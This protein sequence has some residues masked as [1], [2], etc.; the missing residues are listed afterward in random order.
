M[1][2]QSRPARRRRRDDVRRE[3]ERLVGARNGRG[4][5]T[6]AT[7]AEKSSAAGMASRPGR[8]A[9]RPSVASQPAPK[10]QRARGH[11]RRHERHRHQVGRRAMS[12]RRPKVSSAIGSV[13]AWAASETPRLSR[14]APGRRGARA[15]S[16]R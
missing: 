3:G 5:R 16:Q 9:G 11:D 4:A 1:H 10:C 6:T 7:S 2:E 14:I 8:G 12:A 15:A 13:A